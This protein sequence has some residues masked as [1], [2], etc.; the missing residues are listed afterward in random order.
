VEVPAL[1]AASV[2]IVVLAMSRILLAVSKNGAVAVAGIAAVMI[3][4][5]GVLYA[6]KPK[7]GKNFIAGLALALGVAI[8][9]GGVVAAAVGERSFHDEGLTGA[10]AQVVDT[11]AAISGVIR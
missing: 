1:G 7:I 3:L 11:G 2:A 6:A 5:I 8:L 4:G 10:I 9:A